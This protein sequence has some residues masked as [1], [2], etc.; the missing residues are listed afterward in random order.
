[1]MG[2]KE[3]L[4]TIT[5]FGIVKPGTN[6]TVSDGTLNVTPI[7]LF[8]QAYFYS[9]ATQTN[10]VASTTNLVNFNNSAVNIGITLVAG[11]DIIVSKTANYVFQSTL[12]INKT[13]TGNDLVDVWVIR[14]G[15]NYPNTNSESNVASAP[16]ILAFSFSFTLAL[17]AGDVIQLAWQSV[18]TAMSLLA[19]PAQ[20]GPSRPATPSARCTIIQI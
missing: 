10:P 17:T 18:D 13:D 16:G 5:D 4:A 2:Y 19:T 8:D 7:A 3:P 1:M 9:T 12:Q 15:V 11:T 6:L 20:A 14:N